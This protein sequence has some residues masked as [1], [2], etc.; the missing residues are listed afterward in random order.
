MIVPTATSPK[1]SSYNDR[2]KLPNHGL[3]GNN[4]A[5]YESPSHSVKLTT[6]EK[7]PCLLFHAKK[8]YYQTPF[9]E[10]HTEPRISRGIRRLL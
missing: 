10:Q 3:F 2:P 4:R 7:A 5:G 6:T 9:P 1:R 8:F